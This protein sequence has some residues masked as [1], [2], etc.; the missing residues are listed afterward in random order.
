MTHFLVH[1]EAG[2][3]WIPGKGALEQPGI[4]EHTAFMNELAD[5]GVVLLAGPLA[6]SESDRIRA[7]LIVD[8]DSEAKI[9]RQLAA[10]PWTRTQQLRTVSVESWNVFV[11]GERLAAAEGQPPLAY[12]SAEPDSNS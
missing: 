8:A 3:G 1:R 2:A 4:A 11:G 5:R 7:V 12:A 10:D 9:H 6:G